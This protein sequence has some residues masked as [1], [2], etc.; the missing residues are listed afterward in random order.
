MILLKMA[1]FWNVAPFSLVEADRSFRDAYCLIIITLIME[2]VRTSET[3]VFNETTRHYI[4]E[5]CHLHT[6][7]V[8]S[9]KSQGLIKSCLA[10]EGLSA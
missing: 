5:S 6:P 4:Q 9:L 10:F 7:C 1:A 8:E 2:A 3:S